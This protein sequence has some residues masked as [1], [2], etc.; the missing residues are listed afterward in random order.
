MAFWLLLSFLP[1]LAVWLDIKISI[2]RLIQP[3]V[4]VLTLLGALVVVLLA[5]LYP[6]FIQ[7]A[8]QPIDSLKSKASLSF[9]GL[10]LSK[11]LVVMQFAISQIMIVGTLVVA[12]QMDFFENR[13]LGFRKDAVISVS[14]PDQQKAEIL[15]QQLSGNPGVKQ[16][17]LSSGAPVLKQLHKF[18]FS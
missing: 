1:Q 5:G 16:F 12:Y 18:Y 13:N 14:I 15:K 4:I 6:A 11:S 17:S 8:F 10:T 2:S 7:S 9:K 3:A